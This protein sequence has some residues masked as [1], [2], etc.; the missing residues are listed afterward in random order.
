MCLWAQKDNLN[1]FKLFHRWK[2][3]MDSTENQKKMLKISQHCLLLA[4]SLT[5][6]FL[7]FL[8]RFSGESRA[9][10]GVVMSRVSLRRNVPSHANVSQTEHF[11][12]WRDIK[13]W[14]YYQ[15]HGGEFCGQLLAMQT[16]PVAWSATDNKQITRA[17]F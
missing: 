14:F 8:T 17:R 10:R 9:L 5:N 1:F 12:G 15:V 16:T 13:L 11:W 7:K 3:P 6:G 2:F 4:T